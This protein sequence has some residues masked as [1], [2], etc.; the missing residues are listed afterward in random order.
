MWS[1]YSAYFICTTAHPT[2]ASGGICTYDPEISPYRYYHNN[3]TTLKTGQW[4]IVP[5]YTAPVC[6]FTTSACRPD[7]HVNSGCCETT[8]NIDHEATVDLWILVGFLLPYFGFQFWKKYSRR[9]F[10]AKMA[11]ITPAVFIFKG[12]CDD[13]PP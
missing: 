2:M 8:K 5:G 9:K 7:Q 12:K 6:V 10:E 13:S 1:F 4:V 3:G 11:G